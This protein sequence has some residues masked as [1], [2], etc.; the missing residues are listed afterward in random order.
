VADDGADLEAALDALYDVDPSE[1]TATRTRLA[2][3]LRASDPGGAKAVKAARR[4]TTAA[5]AMN[6]VS[7][8]DPALVTGYLDR[9]AELR[10]AQ[11]GALEGGREALR[12]ATR[13]QRDAL[14]GLTD[15]ALAVLGDRANDGYRA[16][17]V[18]TLHA[19]VVDD[20]VGEQLRRGRIVKEVSGSSG[21]PAVPELTVVPPLPAERPAKKRAPKRP[22][23]KAASAPAAEP[24]A[25]QR[26]AKEEEATARVEADAAATAG[27]EARAE[28]LRRQLA[29]AE[30]AA[31]SAR[32]EADAAEAAATAAHTQA[33]QLEE[34][35]EVAR[36]A[37]READTAAARARRDAAQLARAATRLRTR[38]GNCAAA[39]PLP[40][41]TGVGRGR[42][43]IAAAGHG[44]RTRWVSRGA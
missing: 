36:R 43:F 44:A 3:E 26:R 35:L 13:A 7:R 33:R 29:E 15:A 5:W 37:A 18:A 16:Q 19:A 14:A 40:R 22:R 30:A 8:D 1:F 28:R 2:T 24:L 41:S 6:R 4:P 17:I 34:D 39:P 9:S 31:E 38:S 21:F 10:D 32:D 27:R 25:E 23:A 11:G 20:A 12:D 42:P